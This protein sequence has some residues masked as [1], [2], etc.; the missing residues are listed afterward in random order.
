MTIPQVTRL[1]PVQQQ[2]AIEIAPFHCWLLPD[3]SNWT[4]FYRQEQGYLI[5]F[6][7]LADFLVSPDGNEILMT[8]VAGVGET[9][10]SHLLHNQIFPLAWSH[11][12]KQVLHA[13]AVI[14]NDKAIAF[15]G[16]SGRGK[17]TLATSFATSGCPFLSDDSLVVTESGNGFI[18]PPGQ[19]TIRLWHDSLD[20]LVSASTL[21]HPQLDY[22]DKACIIADSQIRHHEKEA[23][24]GA[25]FCLEDDR[26]ESITIRKIRGQD[27]ILY[28]VRNS[29]V[30]DVEDTGTLRRNFAQISTLAER[31]PIFRLGFP[32]DYAQL[33]LVR[34]RITETV[35]KLP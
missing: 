15:L 7:A 12:G 33:S 16:Q 30:L 13:S 27:A 23:R 20:N 8:P 35:N 1:A 29:L 10:L 22:T 26:S 18:V 25:L 19:A 2:A 34:N 28:L 4:G 9:T 24:L 3:G 5:R 11:Q 31:I 21:M 6:P 14:I 17:S 32:H